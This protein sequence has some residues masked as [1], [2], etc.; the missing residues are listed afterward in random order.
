MMSAMTFGA[1]KIRNHAEIPGTEA[2][3]KIADSRP[4]F[5]IKTGQSGRDIE[6]GEA[7]LRILLGQR[8]DRL[9][10]REEPHGLPG[11]ARSGPEKKA[12]TFSLPQTCR[13]RTSAW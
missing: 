7:P 10:L 6:E 9:G 4:E 13:P 5:Y 11:L 8:L 3:L 12:N 2:S 1:K